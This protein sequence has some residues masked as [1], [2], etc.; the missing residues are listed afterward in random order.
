MKTRLTGQVGLPVVEG[1]ITQ[2]SGVALCAVVPVYE[3]PGPADT[4]KSEVW[5]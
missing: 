1:A 4:S 5:R 3:A 2:I